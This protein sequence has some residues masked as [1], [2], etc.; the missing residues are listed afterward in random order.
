MHLHHHT[1]YQTRK[2]PN[3]RSHL[4][5]RLMTVPSPYLYLL[6]KTHCKHHYPVSQTAAP[7]GD[8]D[9]KEIL[10]QPKH[11]LHHQH[12][13]LCIKLHLLC[14]NLNQ[15]QPLCINNHLLHRHLPLLTLHLHL[16]FLHHQDQFYEDLAG[17]VEVKQ[18]N[19]MTLSNRSSTQNLLFKIN[20][21]QDSTSLCTHMTW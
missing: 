3:N 7:E 20:L 17:L 5:Y 4:W 13:P 15:C 21:Q 19:T 2:L 10:N 16:R 12:L 9:R 6:C 8:Q 14:T 18:V 1:L 11:L